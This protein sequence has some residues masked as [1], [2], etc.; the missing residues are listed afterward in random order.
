MDKNKKIM[1]GVVG[2]GL[3]GL[4]YFLFFKDKGAQAQTGKDG[5]DNPMTGAYQGNKPRSIGKLYYNY[6]YSTTYSWV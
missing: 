2:L 6:H 1:V 4:A 3:A 5:L